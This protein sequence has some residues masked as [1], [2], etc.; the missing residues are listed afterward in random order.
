MEGLG[1]LLVNDLHVGSEAV[2][3]AA[4]R[5]LQENRME[6]SKQASKEAS[7]LS[8]IHRRQPQRTYHIKERGWR[9]HHA[10]KQGFMEFIAGSNG[11]N[12]PHNLTA[13]MDSNRKTCNRPKATWL[14]AWHTLVKRMA[15][16]EPP[17]RAA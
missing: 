4:S 17:M 11:C 13:A 9:A 5:Y 6:G 8:P 2:Q 16:T 3:E 7:C 14:R 15:T 12:G 1:Q 10:F